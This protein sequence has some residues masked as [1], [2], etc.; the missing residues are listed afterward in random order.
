MT[1]RPARHP[2]APRRCPPPVAGTREEQPPG[3]GQAGPETD[4]D[5][6]IARLVA[7]APPLTSSSA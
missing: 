5:A 7:G 1:K 4:L 3:A 6:H 2:P